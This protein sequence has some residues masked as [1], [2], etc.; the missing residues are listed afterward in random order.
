M[1]NGGQE[2]G[3][4]TPNNE[5]SDLIPRMPRGELMTWLR[6][7]EAG[8]ENITKHGYKLAEKAG[9]QLRR[10]LVRKDP[11]AD[12]LRRRAKCITCTNPDGGAGTCRT[13]SIIYITTTASAHMRGGQ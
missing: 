12:L 9:L 6:M 11:W 4:T 1:D 10:A 2:G 7:V 13:R 5:V 3:E 8:I